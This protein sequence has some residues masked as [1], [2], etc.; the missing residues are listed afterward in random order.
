VSFSYT[1]KPNLLNEFRF[2]YT[3]V[4]F[5][6][7]NSFDGK[8]FWQSLG[9]Q[10]LA[11]T[12][13]FFNGLPEIDIAGLTGLTADRLNGANRSRTRQFNENLSWLKGRHTMKLG[14]DIRT[15]LGF[16]PLGFIGG[17]SYGTVEFNN[18]FSGAPFRGLPAGLARLYRLR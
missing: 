7:S 12:D 18:T 10:G 2:G 3:T 16:S 11:S 14:L 5:G 17:D 8:A 13:P 1:F 9:F 6:N 4:S 15:I